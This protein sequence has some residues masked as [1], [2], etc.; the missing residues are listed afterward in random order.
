LKSRSLILCA[1]LIW[2]PI[3]RKLKSICIPHIGQ[4]DKISNFMYRYQ[5]TITETGADPRSTEN[6]F[7]LLPV[8]FLFTVRSTGKPQH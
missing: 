4:L 7:F 2:M 1:L 6:N 3:S 8:P 5:Y